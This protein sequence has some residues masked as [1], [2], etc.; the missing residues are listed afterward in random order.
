MGIPGFE[1]YMFIQKL[2]MY[3]FIHLKYVYNTFTYIYIF[4]VADICAMDRSLIV[5][6]SQEMR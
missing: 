4:T 3:I 2:Y 1:C 5:I 6:L